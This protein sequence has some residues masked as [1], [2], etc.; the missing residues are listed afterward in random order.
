MWP[1]DFLLNQNV[2]LRNELIPDPANQRI[3]IGKVIANAGFDDLLEFG[4]G[5]T[6]QVCPRDGPHLIKPLADGRSNFTD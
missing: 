3:D 6:P 2:E 4:F 1:S 5:I